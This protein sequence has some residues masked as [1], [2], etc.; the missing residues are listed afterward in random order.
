VKVA[1]DDFGSGFSKQSYLKQIPADYMKIDQP[2][3]RNLETDPADQMIVPS[4]INLGQKLGFSIVAEGIE[5]ERACKILKHLGCEQGQGYVI[6]RPMTAQDFDT[7][8]D[9]HG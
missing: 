4:I 3:I 6:A 1:I 5:T 9:R 7:W 2:F 8:L